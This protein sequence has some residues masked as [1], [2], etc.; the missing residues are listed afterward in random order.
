MLVIEDRR[1]SF[2]EA[3]MGTVEATMGDHGLLNGHVDGKLGD[4]SCQSSSVY[5]AIG[6]PQFENASLGCCGTSK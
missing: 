3:L 6:R 5:L 4:V 2:C 1:K